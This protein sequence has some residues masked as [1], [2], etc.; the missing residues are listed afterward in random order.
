MVNC[1]VA[2][3]IGP[4]DYRYLGMFC[5]VVSST[6][7]GMGT[8]LHYRYRYSFAILFHSHEHIAALGVTAHAE[9]G[10]TAQWRA[11]FTVHPD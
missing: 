8:L 10:V 7:T 9:L 11:L 4:L 5:R 1:Q 3:V 6:G 2:F